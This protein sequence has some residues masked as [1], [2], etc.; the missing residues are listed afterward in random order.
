MTIVINYQLSDSL[1]GKIRIFAQPFFKIAA[2]LL[3][4]VS[5]IFKGVLSANHI[6]LL[7]NIEDL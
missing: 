3:F 2:D 6:F 1:R 7:M 4:L 5:L